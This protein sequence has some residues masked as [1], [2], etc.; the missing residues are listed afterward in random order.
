MEMIMAYFKA[1]PYICLKAEFK[2]APVSDTFTW[3]TGI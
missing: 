1:L 2:C 3:A